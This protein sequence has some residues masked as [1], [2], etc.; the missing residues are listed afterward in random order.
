MGA[1]MTEAGPGIEAVL[2]ISWLSVDDRADA[3]PK[4]RGD[5]AYAAFA[6]ETSRYAA[7]RVSYLCIANPLCPLQSLPQGQRIYMEQL[8]YKHSPVAAALKFKEVNEKCVSTM[9]GTYTTLG[10]LMPFT[11]DKPCMFGFHA[12]S[13]GKMNA[14]PG[15]YEA[16]TKPEAQPLLDDYYNQ[17]QDSANRILM[18][19]TGKAQPASKSFYPRR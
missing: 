7:S 13:N 3:Y 16:F 17:I 10:L 9:G 15:L 18:P 1:W 2:L 12:M 11:F 8:N 14:I 5:P 6:E 19:M 4:L